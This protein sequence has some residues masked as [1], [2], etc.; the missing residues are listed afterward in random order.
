[1]KFAVV[2][3]MSKISVPQADAEVSLKSPITIGGVAFAG[4]R[5]I[6]KVEVSVSMAN[7]AGD[8]NWAPAELLSEG[9]T[10]TWRLWQYN[11]HPTKTGT[12]VLVVRATDGSGMLQIA[13]NAPI[14]PSGSTGYHS[15]K[16][17]VVE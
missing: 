11:W 12:Y 4:N 2:K 9:S 16:A 8:A 7:E 14:F 5:G 6:Q 17:R 3:T 10:I 15:V 13:E 1:M